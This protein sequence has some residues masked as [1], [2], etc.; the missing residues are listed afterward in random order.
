VAGLVLVATVAT[1]SVPPSYGSDFLILGSSMLFS[2][3]GLGFG[4]HVVIRDRV[5]PNLG[6]LIGAAFSGGLVG[7]LLFLPGFVAGAALATI[8]SLKRSEGVEWALVFFPF[9]IFFAGGSAIC[10]RYLVWRF[11]GNQ[12]VVAIAAGVVGAFVGDAL[13]T[14]TI[15]RPFTVG[16]DYLHAPIAMTAIFGALVAAGLAWAERNVPSGNQKAPDAA[17]TNDTNKE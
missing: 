13:M 17:S 16:P 14:F 10:A 9:W 8:F 2:A 3:L 12:I 7:A 6:G 5:P 11:L 1:L 4:S 15:S